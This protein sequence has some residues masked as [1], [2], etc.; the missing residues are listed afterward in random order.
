MSAQLD[1]NWAKTRL[2]IT[3]TYSGSVIPDQTF[4][5]ERVA[6][7]EAT[8]DGAS[9]RDASVHDAAV[10][11]VSIHNVPVHDASVRDASEHDAPDD[12]ELADGSIARTT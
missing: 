8:D 5:I 10:H 11:D 3:D 6:D 2:V 12:I 4:R 1:P 9:H 7:D